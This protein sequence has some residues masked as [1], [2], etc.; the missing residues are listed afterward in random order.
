MLRTPYLPALANISSRSV[1]KLSG[2]S[3][4]AHSDDGEGLPS[5]SLPP[6]VHCPFQW[7][8]NGPHKCARDAE[9]A[10]E[11]VNT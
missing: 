6:P 7:L 8:I 5:P 1:L 3:L 9:I 4:S 11:V 10:E 2:G